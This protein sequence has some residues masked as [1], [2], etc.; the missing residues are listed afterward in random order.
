[1]LNVCN[2]F[3]NNMTYVEYARS[4]VEYYT[5]NLE[6]AKLLVDIGWKYNKTSVGF[7]LVPPEISVSDLTEYKKAMQY[8]NLSF[9]YI[10]FKYLKTLLRKNILSSYIKEIIEANRLKY[11]KFRFLISTGPVLDTE[12]RILG[13]DNRI[14]CLKIDM[15]EKF[16]NSKEYLEYTKLYNNVSEAC[17]ELETSNIPLNT[18]PKVLQEFYNML[19]TKIEL[20]SDKK[21]YNDKIFKIYGIEKITEKIDIMFFLP[22]GCFKYLSSFVNVENVRKIMFWEFHA[23]NSKEST[24]KLLNKNMNNKNVLIIDN[25]YSGKTMKKIKEKIIEL[26]GKPILLG[27]NPKNITNLQVVDYFMI[28][29]T[30]YKKDELNI[31]KENFFEEIYEKT[32]LGGV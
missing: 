21:I 15:V 12:I 25:M 6:E 17:K 14:E 4:G 26:G 13:S 3:E 11:K 8:G 22:F 32:L 20:I 28:L 7:R 1:M 18:Q 5:E 31:N 10:Y 9:N 24:F 30:I 19:Q 23:D 16:I 29:N 2:I 27:L